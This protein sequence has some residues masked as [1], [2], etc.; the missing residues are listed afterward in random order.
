MWPFL[1]INKLCDRIFIYCSHLTSLCKTVKEKQETSHIYGRGRPRAGK[2]KQETVPCNLSA[3][4]SR[5]DFDI[6]FSLQMLHSQC[7]SFGNGLICLLTKCRLRD[8]GFLYVCSRLHSGS[9]ALPRQIKHIVGLSFGHLTQTEAMAREKVS[10]F[11]SEGVDFCL[12]GRGAAGG[13]SIASAGR[14]CGA[15]GREGAPS[16]ASQTAITA[17]IAAIRRSYSFSV[18][19]P[20]MVSTLSISVICCGV[21]AGTLQRTQNFFVNNFP[22][23]LPLA[24]DHW[25]LVFVPLQILTD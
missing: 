11:L 21:I 2:G 5:P 18:V 23:K 16:S 7:M 19:V 20:G 15:R 3:W 17:L 14:F 9:L 6:S 25:L 22:G 24:V 10:S 12:L 4:F 1:K 8:P 13:V